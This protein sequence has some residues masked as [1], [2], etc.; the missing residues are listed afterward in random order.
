ML[1]MNVRSYTFPVARKSAQIFKE[2]N[3]NGLV[4]TGGMHASVAPDE[5]L[6]V[7]EFDTVCQGPGE[8]IIVDLST[9]ITASVRW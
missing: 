4:L 5:M 1:I 7:A 6:E 9:A 2:V 3:P 8:K